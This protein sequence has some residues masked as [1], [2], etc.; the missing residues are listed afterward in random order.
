VP[1]IAR[2]GRRCV[3]TTA[4]GS[5]A[6][7]VA[8]LAA[9]ALAG[10]AAAATPLRPAATHV[11]GELRGIG[12]HGLL[13]GSP[14]APVKII[15][16]ANL[17]CGPCIRVHR[18]VVPLVIARYVRTGV[19]SLE[20]RSVANS[21]RSHDLARSA[22]AASPQHRGW[23]FIQLSYLRGTR[24]PSA[25][26]VG[27]LGLDAQRWRQDLRRPAFETLIR[28]AISVAGVARFQGDP[29]FLVRRYPGR[30]FV[31]LTEPQSVGAFAGA[32]AKARRSRP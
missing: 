3:H 32:I 4:A 31:V 24:D 22:H 14:R 11:R 1:S 18:T 2:R 19:A 9:L 20:F 10:G 21:A 15:E 25:R 17:V 12:Q 16:Y 28:A 6:A 26:L 23:D 8:V 13:L 29:V 7:F 27:A 5:G 30:P